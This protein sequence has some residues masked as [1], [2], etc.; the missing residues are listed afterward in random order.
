M[1]NSNLKILL[2]EIFRVIDS[3]STYPRISA[4][5]S[6]IACCGYNRYWYLHVVGS[7]LAAYHGTITIVSFT[8]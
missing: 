7:I 8:D 4:D 2:D 1:A 5:T 3:S 6:S